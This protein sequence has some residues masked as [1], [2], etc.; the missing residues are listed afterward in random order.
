MNYQKGN[1]TPIDPRSGVPTA[2]RGIRDRPLAFADG[3]IP[4]L[5]D[6]VI[7]PEPG[8][9]DLDDLLPEPIPEQDPDARMEDIARVAQAVSESATERII[10]KLEPRIRKEVEKAVTSALLALKDADPTGQGG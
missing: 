10:R 1:N 2:D 4:I 9:I 3:G 5:Q 8:E 6:V 7:P